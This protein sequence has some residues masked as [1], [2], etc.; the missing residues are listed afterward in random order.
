MCALG[1]GF[2]T[3]YY[4]RAL[5]RPA[6]AH[7]A[8]QAAAKTH[9][10]GEMALPALGPDRASTHGPR[11]PGP[12]AQAQA[13]AFERAMGPA[14]PPPADPVTP[15]PLPAG[16]G[17]PPPPAQK[18]PGELAF[19]RRLAGPAFAKSATDSGAGAAGAAER[20]PVP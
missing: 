12:P 16:V 8:A 3:W 10:Q 9:A 15:M 6:Q 17:T 4:A 18:T 20:D 11:G 19:E 2:L 1:L 13:S 7:Q 14:P 5:A